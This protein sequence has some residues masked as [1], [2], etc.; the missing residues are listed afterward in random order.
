MSR[1]L[2]ILTLAALLAGCGMKGPLYYPSDKPPAKKP[3]QAPSPAS[4]DSKEQT[5]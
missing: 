1:L 5:R 4:S 3:V 2:S